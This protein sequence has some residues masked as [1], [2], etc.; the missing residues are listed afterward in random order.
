MPSM[1]TPIKYPAYR[2]YMQMR[3]WA[4]RGGAGVLPPA[5]RIAA[6]GAMMTAN[7]VLRGGRL[8]LLFT[9]GMSVEQVADVLGAIDGLVASGR[10]APARVM[11]SPP[12]GPTPMPG[13][14]AGIGGNY[15]PVG[16]RRA[17]VDPGV[18]PRVKP[19]SA[20]TREYYSHG[21]PPGSHFNRHYG[22]CV[23]EF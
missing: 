22:R 20:A 1:D 7:R 19:Y 13:G 23:S 12:S 9:S 15:F 21:C 3:D 18:D 2:R 8:D 6:S 17:A 5:G 10:A 4:A 16:T 11:V 14:A